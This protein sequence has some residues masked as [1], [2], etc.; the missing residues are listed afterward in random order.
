M[1]CLTEYHGSILAYFRSN[2]PD[3]SSDKPNI[4]ILGPCYGSVSVNVLF[5]QRSLKMPPILKRWVHRQIVQKWMI[6][7]DLG[8]LDAY[9]PPSGN[10]LPAFWKSPVRRI[11]LVWRWFYHRM[12]G[13]FERKLFEESIRPVKIDFKQLQITV[14]KIYEKVNQAYAN[15]NIKEIALYCGPVYF[16]TLKSQIEKRPIEF[17]FKWELH[18]MIKPPKLVS[19]THTKVGIDSNKYLA[20]VIYKIHSEQSL[21]TFSKGFEKKGTPKVL[22]EYYVFQHKTWMQPYKWYLW[23]KTEEA[24]PDAVKVKIWTKHGNVNNERSDVLSSML[25]F[26]FINNIVYDWILITVGLDFMT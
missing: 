5:S 12:K 10:C 16:E 2:N 21:T 13:W 8:I 23:G 25:D 24:S 14:G 18:R 4:G 22:T 11:R 15:G 9:V 3:K 6:P 19:F 17:K 20:Q 26:V 1:N 7:E